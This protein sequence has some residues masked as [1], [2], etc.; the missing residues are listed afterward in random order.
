MKITYY[1]HSCFLVETATARLILDPFLTGN[2]A[3]PL[4]V[5]DVRCDYI[6]LS[7]GHEDHSCDALAIAK[8]NNATIVANY[9][10][11]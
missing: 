5:A 6:L 11:A 1:G 8:A 10:L 2:S 9:E 3:A 4:A 7:H